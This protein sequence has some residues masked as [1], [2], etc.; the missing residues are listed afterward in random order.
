MQVNLS[1]IETLFDVIKQLPGTN[2]SEYYFKERLS[3]AK[4]LVESERDI[5][6]AMAAC[7]TWCFAGVASR[8][9][10]LDVSKLPLDVLDEFDD[11]DD[12]NEADAVQ[13]F[14]LHARYP[15][16]PTGYY[17]VLPNTPTTDEPAVRQ[18]WRLHDARCLEVQAFKLPP[19]S[20][21]WRQFQ[22]FAADKKKYVY[23][24]EDL[25]M[26]GR[27]RVLIFRK[28][29]LGR[30]QCLSL[31]QRERWVIASAED[32]T[33]EDFHPSDAS[34]P[35]P[36]SSP[37]ACDDD[38]EVSA[39]VPE[40]DVPTQ[41]TPELMSAAEKLSESAQRAARPSPKRS[42]EVEE[43]APVTKK[44]K[45]VHS[46]EIPQRQRLTYH[47]RIAAHGGAGQLPLFITTSDPVPEVIDT[48]E[49]EVV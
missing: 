24:G 8:L 43:D 22:F 49:V 31:N 2:Y 37:S 12:D 18:K 23:A 1:D 30:D 17:K 39:P 34:S 6:D 10:V 19:C 20:D 25:N 3:A 21:N 45:M 44:L 4:R 28:L 33:T 42:V 48:S 38:T 36:P 13:F 16:R 15:A 26:M 5:Q 27:G 35:L 11:D 47:E 41:S 32:T 9:E 40:V 29:G 7:N 46:A 14:R